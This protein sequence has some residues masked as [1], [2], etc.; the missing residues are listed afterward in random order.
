M[1]SSYSNF[2][3]MASFC[4]LFKPTDYFLVPSLNAPVKLKCSVNLIS[5]F[6]KKI[7]S[8]QESISLGL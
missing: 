3:V 5:F 7:N 8:Q 2:F 6:Y 1:Y 4:F